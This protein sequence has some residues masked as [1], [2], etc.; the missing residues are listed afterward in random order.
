M[1]VQFTPREI[2]QFHAV[3][4]AFDPLGTLNPGKGIPVLKNCQEYRAIDA[5]RSPETGPRR[6]CA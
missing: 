1:S 3:K 4:A 6:E 2:E 5:G